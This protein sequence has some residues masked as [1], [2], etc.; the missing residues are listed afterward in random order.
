MNVKELLDHYVLKRW[1][2]EA[3][4]GIIQ[5]NVGRKVSDDPKLD[6]THRYKFLSHR[7]ISLASHASKY[8]EIFELVNNALYQL[9]L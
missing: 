8:E 6:A 7:C 4:H 3:R 5:D 2:I 9:Q 1:T